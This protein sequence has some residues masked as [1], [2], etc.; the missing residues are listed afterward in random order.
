KIEIL[1]AVSKAKDKIHEYYSATGHSQAGKYYGIA[2]LLNPRSKSSTWLLPEWAPN[3]DDPFNWQAYYW[4]EMKALYDRDYTSIEP[5]Q[6]RRQLL[7]HLCEPEY[8]IDDIIDDLNTSV[9]P[10]PRT[11]GD[12]STVS[13]AE[14]EFNDYRM[15][16]DASTRRNNPFKY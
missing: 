5:T 10:I 3:A 7:N 4:K 13:D 6:R 11:R 14:R 2:I 9:D 15:W 12:T 8:D 16:N 1:K